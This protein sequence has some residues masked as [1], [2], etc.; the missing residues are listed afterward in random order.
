M[1]RRKTATGTG[2][3][4]LSTRVPQSVFDAFTEAHVAAGLTQAA[5]V[6]LALDAWLERH[7]PP[8]G[9]NVES[10]AILAR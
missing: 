1:G 4:R 8:A 6:T 9:T 7:P 10:A 2:G 3:H 5:A